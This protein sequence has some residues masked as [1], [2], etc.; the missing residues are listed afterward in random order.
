MVCSSSEN[1]G[2]EACSGV[3][4]KLSSVSAST[5]RG[6]T[7]AGKA[8]VVY[9]R[10]IRS[11]LRESG[12]SDS[13]VSV[14]C[15]SWRPGT[16]KRYASYI[17]RW[18]R[19]THRRHVDPVS[20]TVSEPLNLLATFL[21]SGLGYNAIRVARSAVSSYLVLKDGVPFVQQ[22]LVIRFIK[23]VFEMNPALPKYPNTW[24]VNVVLNY[25]ELLHPHNKLTL[26][27]LSQTLDMLLALLS[28]QRCQTILKLS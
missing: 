15:A 9:L 4:K 24:N 7:S 19:Y 22:K 26:D 16:Q 28:G 3:C 17:Q 18:C 6:K 25:L 27:M 1:V 12:L 2:K 11:R 14:V 10:N 21:D 23:G 8:Q 13:A 20:P 5:S